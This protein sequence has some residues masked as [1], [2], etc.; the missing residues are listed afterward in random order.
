M[1]DRETRLKQLHNA[2][3]E[4][5]VILDGGMGT[6]IQNLK[7]DEDAFRAE[8]FKD[9]DRDVQGNNDL[10][11][12]TQPALLRNI[13]ADYLAAGADIIETNTFNSTQLS[14]SDYGLESL[15]YELNVAGAQLA[16]QIADEFTEREPHKPRF[17]AG[18]VGP[19][20]RTA[21]ISPDVNNPGYRNVDF[22]TLYEN[23]YEAVKGLV[24][25]GSDLI[26]IETIFDTLNAKAAIYAT[27]Q[28]FEDSGIELPIMISGTITD[29][30]GRTL[31]GQTTEAFWNSIAHAR[32]ISVGLNCAL[33]ADALRPYIEELSNRAT[34]Y[35][36]A[37]PNA[38]LPNE[39]GEY[40]QTPEE[41]ADIIEAFARDGFLNIIGGC[42]GS[43]PDHIEAIANAVAKY[44]PRQIPEIK[45][46]LRLSGLEPFTGDEN[47]LFIN[48]GERTNVTGSKRFLRLIKE[49]QYEEA[50]SVARDQVENGAQ[51][52]D[53]N[54]DEGMLDSKDVM[55]R[56]LNLVASEP[57]IARVPIMIDS[58]KWDVIEAGLRC[59]Q[60]KAVVNSI[61]L[62]EGE[63]EFIARAKSC[64][65]Y[66]AAVVV[67]A[68]DEQGQ[69]DSF[70]RKTE[71]CKRSY[72]TLV[73][74][75]FN[76][77][78]IIFDP[79]IF[80]IATGIE[81]HNNYAVDFIEATGW[82]RKNLPHASI[83]GGVSNVSFS[84]RGNDVVRE[85]IHSVFLYH[86]I[87][88]GMN[89][90]IVN[91]GQ[92]VVYDEIDPELRELVTDVVLNRR[93]D[94]TDRLLE[95]AER[96]RG[97]VGK[98]REEDLA[99][100]EW[101]VQKR[102][103]HALVKG[104][105]TYIIEDTEACR[106]E[107]D[108]P[109][110][111]IEGPL[112]DGMNVV[113]DLFG[114]G[115]MFL[116][117]VVKSARVMKQAVA[118]LIPYIEAEKTEGQQAKGKILMATV[119]GDVHDIGKNIVGVVLQ[120]NNY[121]VIDL[122]VMVPCEKILA[123]AKEE[124]VDIIGLSGLITPSLDE[125]VHVAREMQR[126]EFDVPLMIGGATT[127]KAHTA[128]K[129][130]PQY[131]NDLAL[132]VSDA[133]RCVNIASQLLSRTAKEPLVESTR[134]EYD[135]IRERRKNRGER[136]KLIDLSAARERDTEI[137][138]DGYQPVKPAFT[139]LKV[140][141]DYDLNELVDYIDWTPFFISW[142]MSGKYPAI[143]DDP[144]RGDAARTLFDDAQAI[145]KRIL[146]EKRLKARAV[147]G[148]WP[149]NRRGDDLV[150]Y[151]DESRQEVLTTLH[152]L[153][154]QD[155][156]SPGKPMLAL[157]DYLLPEDSDQCDY[158]G[159]FAVTAG[160][161]AD[162]LAEEYKAKNDDY[163]AIMVKALADR[164]A[165]AFAER[166]HERV[167]K[168]FWGYD[169]EE[170]L[171]NDALIRER[172]RGIRP[173]PGYPAC[174]DHTEKA[175]LFDLLQA[176]DNAG[177]EL[178]EHFAMLPAAAVSGWYFAHPEAKYFSVG[179]I[180]QDQVEDYAKRKGISKAEAERWLAP[181][182]AYDPA[183]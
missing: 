154:Q 91:P 67:M 93:E 175:A 182:L 85:A 126:L 170:T 40:D 38:G 18:A 111:V 113:G 122:G 32:P 28:Y 174:P 84:F 29:A 180:G 100:R 120:C 117:Q 169:P 142:D 76:P 24:E 162:D 80:A 66:G 163:N 172:Y 118:H 109:I 131:K 105:T 98:A 167:R 179:K 141:D 57:D 147:I 72:D 37:H 150:V 14:Q 19:T 20:S 17:V 46:A 165:E 68:F 101:P 62:K 177:M 108:R 5:I 7:L 171:D 1:S 26:L 168:E 116:P 16:R 112:M 3:K 92:L 13:H 59:I 121:E 11:N 36:S 110:H 48:V 157:S 41:M 130:E 153:R 71:I 89:M 155:E 115:K 183:E 58:S 139:G 103:E 127:S 45:P 30:S 87:K 70:K 27:Q 178:T 146:E 43:R 73:G 15:A 6:M 10:L 136:T 125:M 173:A 25:G 33:G 114:D 96:Y 56:F 149:A 160:I 81:E 86:A 97:E 2:L 53:I 42:C 21:S 60:G 106:Q 49:E 145:L 134:T 99:W 8:R 83:S 143:F 54:M 44:P 166:M 79:N 95:A 74:M 12:L 123:T 23:Y 151:T 69:A 133:S 78:D 50:L 22:Q 176:P 128:V 55:V 35:V 144:K 94:G 148:F 77:S 158:V 75:G 61:S 156:K 82:I 164:L 4:R 64:M 107:A 124:N 9:Y 52:I 181:S 152:H 47:T 102:L 137:S 135:K 161:G 34:T 39:F 88:A 63:A 140:F 65:R 104:I 132:Y 119:K 129:I 159:G 31:S 51:I 138:F 90:G